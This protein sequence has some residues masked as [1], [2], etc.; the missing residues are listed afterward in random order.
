MDAF[1]R[2][3]MIRSVSRPI[4]LSAN[5]LILLDLSVLIRE[6]RGS[7]NVE[8]SLQIGVF[9]CKTN[10]IILYCVQCAAYCVKEYKLF[11]IK[12]LWQNPA[13]SA[14]LPGQGNKAKTKPIQSQFTPS[15]RLGAKR[16]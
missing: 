11:E 7:T 12:I 1:G 4:N 10:P 5:S 13:S 15:A 14:T 9:F 16:G 8:S 2:R 3:L 6:I